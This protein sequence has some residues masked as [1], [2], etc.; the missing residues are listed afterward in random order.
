MNLG[1]LFDYVDSKLDA[2]V[3]VVVEE[4]VEGTLRTVTANDFRTR[5]NN[6]AKKFVDLGAQPGDKVAF[7]S[8]NRVEYLIGVVAAIKAR[9]VHVNV[10]YRYGESELL[11]LF[12]NSDARFVIFESDYADKV[13]TIRGDLPLCEHFIEVCDAGETV[14]SW[15]KS[16]DELSGSGDGEPLD[17]E[18]SPEDLL[19]M[20]TGGTT[21]MPKGVMWEQYMFWSML[22]RNMLDPM[23]P[24]PQRPEDIDVA[25]TGGGLNSLIVLPLMHGAG[26][27]TAINALG[28]GNTCVIPR[29]GGFD[30]DLSLRCIDKHNIRVLTISGDAF[31]KPIVDALDAN[32]EGYQLQS[33]R[34]I[35]STAMI[36]SPHNKKA[37]LRHLPD[38][39]IFDNVGSSESSLSAMAVVSKDT[40]LDTSALIMQL[41]PGAKV[42]TED[43]REVEPGS[44]GT[45]FLAV[46]GNLPLG[47]YK[48]EKKT[49]ETF[50][51]VDGVRYSRPGDWVE[52]LA[53]GSVKFLGRGNV[54]INSGGEKIYPEEVE[55]ALKS[56]EAVRDCLIVGVADDRLGQAVTAV[57]QLAADRSAD[58]EQ[59]QEHVRSQLSGYKVPRHIVFTDELYRAPNGKADYPAT[60][61]LAEQD[62]ANRKTADRS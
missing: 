49:A 34:V 37:I 59:L 7:Y 8:K 50:I 55:S 2:D 39:L 29:S 38:L 33:L 9:L 44:G 57:V 16:F 6:L 52:P 1:D 46:G 14:A 27:Y 23:A 47:Y 45:G 26:L 36:F 42:F 13:A 12:D 61:E 30:A 10:N 31:A 43:L 20:Y 24:V 28:Y 53:D 60:K 41:T 18:R 3:P 4:G 5:S 25:A 40:D 48:D 58:A 54:C 51:T 11:Y 21:G 22:G 35:N 15:A 32:P 19:L 17:I 56:H 62:V